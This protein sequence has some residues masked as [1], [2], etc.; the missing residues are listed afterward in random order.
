[1]RRRP[2]RTRAPQ[3]FVHECRHFVHFRRSIDLSCLTPACSPE[4]NARLRKASGFPQRGQLSITLTCPISDSPT[5]S[6]EE[7]R[8][9]VICFTSITCSWTR[10]PHPTHKSPPGVFLMYDPH[11]SQN[12]I[13]WLLL[14]QWDRNR[15][16][17]D[18]GTKVT[19]ETRAPRSST[20]PA[21]PFA[22]TAGRTSRA[23]S[24][25]YLCH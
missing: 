14:G 10:F 11:F 1:M 20:D 19:N 2:R 16:E 15:G 3:S 8:R 9:F 13:H 23:A 4:T 17:A 5:T 24:A 18:T 22:R 21:C 25:R 6:T 12:F 7:R